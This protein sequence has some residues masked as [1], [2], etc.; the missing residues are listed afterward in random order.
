MGEGVSA[1]ENIAYFFNWLS[2]CWGKA[3]ENKNTVAKKYCKMC[4]LSLNHM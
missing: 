3:A 1:E 2:I 4:Y